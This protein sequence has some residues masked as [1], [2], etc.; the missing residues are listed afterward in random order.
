MSRSRWLFPVFLLALLPAGVRAQ[1]AARTDSKDVAEIRAYRLTI[2][3]VRKWFAAQKGLVRLEQEHPELAEAA[4]QFDDQASWSL[5]QFEHA[6][7]AV[8]EASAALRANGLTA[9]QFAVI[10]MAYMQAGMLFWA[11]EQGNKVDLTSVT[12]DMNPANR[13]FYR[14]HEAELKQMQGEIEA[15]QRK[16]EAADTASAP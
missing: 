16:G 12:R 15:L 7:D 4:D 9:R 1:G 14:E 6:V 2:G 10:T 11:N 8:P 3:D 13:T 5:D